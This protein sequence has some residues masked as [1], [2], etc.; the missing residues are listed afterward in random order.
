MLSMLRR[1]DEGLE[2]M[3]GLPRREAAQALQKYGKVRWALP[4]SGALRCAILRL[5]T[6]LVAGSGCR[7]CGVE[8][9]HSA[10]VHSPPR[11]HPALP[12]SNS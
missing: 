6:T 4:P 7:E 2:F 3:R 8:G 5:L 10:C 1:F 11:S 12:C 9:L